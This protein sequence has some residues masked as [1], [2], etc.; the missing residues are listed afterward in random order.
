[1]ERG[2]GR[3][4]GSC[5]M[6]GF[7]VSYMILKVLLLEVRFK[8]VKRVLIILRE[9]EKGKLLFYTA[10]FPLL[11]VVSIWREEEKEK[12]LFYTAIFLHFSF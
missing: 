10:I 4:S 2:D 3:E 6:N 5:P 12:L 8:H 11:R 7:I 1:V 9:E